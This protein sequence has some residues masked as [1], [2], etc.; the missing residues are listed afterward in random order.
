[1]CGIKCD[2]IFQLNYVT[3]APPT[4]F[5]LSLRISWLIIDELTIFMFLSIRRYYLR[6]FIG[7]LVR[8]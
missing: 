1:M 8:V 4:T 7:Y 3:Q 2:A 6:F 5:V